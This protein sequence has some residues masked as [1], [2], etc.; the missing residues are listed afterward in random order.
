M[1]E[2]ADIEDAFLAALGLLLGTKD[3][4]GEWIL[5]PVV[6][7]LETYGGQLDEEEIE[8]A[9]LGF[10]AVYVIWSGSDLREVNRVDAVAVRVSVI[11]CDRN[12]RGETAARRGA[13]EAPGVYA[14]MDQARA[15]LHRQRVLASPGW[16]TAS[17]D[18]EGPLAYTREGGLA[19]YEQVYEIK[20]RL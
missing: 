16:T 3:E 2:I 14:V 8:K 6:R 5:P 9:A 17:L 18:R 15:L 20:A 12:L 7:A 11:F 13:P 19:I 4:G 1:Y 10:P